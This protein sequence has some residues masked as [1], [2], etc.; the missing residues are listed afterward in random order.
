MSEIEQGQPENH[1]M[2]LPIDWH[3]SEN[4][5]SRYASNVFV[6]A[7]EH[8]LILS[9]FETIPPMLL[10]SPE[11]NRAKLLQ[12]GAVRAECVARIIVAPD[13]VP[14]LIQALQTTLDGYLAVKRA[15]E[16]ESS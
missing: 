8:E 5:Q 12:Q 9:F 6:Q 11:E 2:S 13:L 1:N 4:I 10:G 7:G 16:G 3:V 14:K 15:Q